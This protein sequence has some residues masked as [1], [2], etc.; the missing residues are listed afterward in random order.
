ME[1]LKLS[2][3]WAKAEVFSAKIVWLFSIIV[4]LSAL[5]F[6]Y[7]GKTTMAKAFVWP[8]VVS[9]L[10]L[11]AVAAGLFMANKPRISQFEQASRNNPGTFLQQELQRTAKSQKELATVFEVL[12]L[13]LIVGGLLIFFLSSPTWRAIGIVIGLVAVFLMAVDSN[14]DTRN[15]IYHK[16]LKDLVNEYGRN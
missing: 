5:G 10:F 7:W 15:T 2:T 8:L 12:P 9:G 3:D 13:L 14:T 1:I 11:V 16:Q 4:L 6:W